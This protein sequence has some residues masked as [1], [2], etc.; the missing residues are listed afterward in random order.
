MPYKSV[1]RCGNVW[2]ASR[3][4][5]SGTIGDS[6]TDD[7]I[8]PVSTVAET[9][10]S[11]TTVELADPR[12]PDLRLLAD[13]PPRN[14]AQMVIACVAALA[15]HSGVAAGLWYGIPYDS[16]DIGG[17]GIG[18]DAI[19]ID[20]IDTKVL[21][22]L[23]P[24]ARAAPGAAS[25]LAT[26]EGVAKPEAASVET[27]DAAAAKPDAANAAP[28][29]DLVLPE[30]EDRLEPPTPDTITIAKQAP[31]IDPP[32]MPKDAPPTP[33][34]TASPAAT[35][36]ASL[37][38]PAAVE[39]VQAGSVS[40]STAAVAEAGRGAAQASAGVV[41]VYGQSVMAA[42]VTTQPQPRQ[43]LST[44][45]TGWL[46][47][48]VIVDFTIALDG[49]IAN[50]RVASSSGHRE[51]DQAALDAVRRTRFPKPPSSLPSNERQYIMPY[52]FR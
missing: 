8:V 47:G 35:Q 28:K 30:V 48:T 1:Y 40:Q 46:T 11:V 50:A 33:K 3:S 34:P 5:T 7:G 12:T 41:K 31:D 38:A 52:Y 51:L 44:G 20:L 29:P 19:G 26:T 43:G 13:I 22:A 23:Q 37:P 10:N 15:L 14:R 25:S 6:G 27:I 42:L 2:V 21:A 49:G 4:M 16:E 18:R 45:T 36:V 32:P 39:A 24:D 17:D 9:A